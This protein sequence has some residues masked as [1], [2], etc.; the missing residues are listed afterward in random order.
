MIYIIGFL[1]L[2][3]YHLESKRSR[4]GRNWRSGRGSRRSPTH[5]IM[6]VQGLSSQWIPCAVALCINILSPHFSTLFAFHI[7]FFEVFSFRRLII[8]QC[9]WVIW[10]AISDYTLPALI[11]LGTQEYFWL[12]FNSALFLTKC[13]IHHFPSLVV[14]IELSLSDHLNYTLPFVFILLQFP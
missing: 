5:L 10:M 12:F 11:A 4:V 1:I 14:S 6:I 2:E 7:S 3:N 9:Q 8:F 13:I